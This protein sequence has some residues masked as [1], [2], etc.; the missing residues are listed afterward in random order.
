MNARHYFQSLNGGGHRDIR[1]DFDL[2][3][4]MVIISVNR[5]DSERG[6]FFHGNS[7][8]GQKLGFNVVLQKLPA[9]FGSPDYMI[10]MLIG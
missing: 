9:V 2:N 4:D 6:V 3:M 1:G 8:D 7:E 5:D 10:L